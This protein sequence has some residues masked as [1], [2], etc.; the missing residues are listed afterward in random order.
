VHR[1][2]IG[3]LCEGEIVPA[4]FNVKDCAL[5]TA[6]GG[7]EPALNLRE[8]RERIA[9]SPPECIFHHFCE[10]VL[11]PTFDD[12]EF[13]NDFA[14]WAA[15]SLRDRSLAEQLGA[16]NPYQYDNVEQLRRQVI[17]V[18][19]SRLNEL[20]FIQWAP[21][22]L[23]F[24]LRKAVT[25]VFDTG[26]TL[27]TPADLVDHIAAMTNS[28]IYFHFVVANWRRPVNVDDF[29]TWLESFGEATVGIVAELRSLEF[30]FMTLAELKSMLIEIA[31]RYG[32][33]C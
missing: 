28:T 23:E 12:A 13:R 5:I 18:I 21:P 1:D 6:M 32:R 14:V 19:D 9:A 11:S 25:V 17:E 27:R 22:G 29:T 24:T 7:L 16:I 3:H 30:Y 8:L 20:T 33:Q 31:G 10:T 26:I 2:S 15:R 4:P